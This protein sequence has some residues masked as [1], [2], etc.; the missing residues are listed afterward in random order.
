MSSSPLYVEFKDGTRLWGIYYGSSDAIL[1][2]LFDTKKEAEDTYFC[3]DD[4][5]FDRMNVSAD[6][7]KL[8]GRDA[9][10]VRFFTSYG[11]LDEGYRE[12]SWDGHASRSAKVVV[13]PYTDPGW[14]EYPILDEYWKWVDADKKDHGAQDQ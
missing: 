4:S 3:G 1:G 2:R 6:E 5:G 11:V 13:G 14:H 10:P 8:A 12:L 7:V 9:E